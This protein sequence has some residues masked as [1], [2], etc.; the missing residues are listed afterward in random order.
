MNKKSQEKPINAH[1]IETAFNE[2]NILSLLETLSIGI[3]HSINIIKEITHNPVNKS[4]LIEIPD[5]GA[6]ANQILLS[7]KQGQPTVDQVY[8]AIYQLGADCQNRIIAF[9][10]GHHWDDKENPGADIDKV[11]SLADTMNEY[12][13]GIYLVKMSCDSTASDLEYEILA[14]PNDN[15]KFSKTQCPT[16]EQFTESE[17]WQIHF[18]PADFIFQ[19][20]AFQSDFDP[21]RESGLY[22]EVGGLGIETKWAGN[23][24]MILATDT[25]TNDN[26]L[27]RIWN[28]KKDEILDMFKGCDI[29]LLYRSGC[30]Q[31]M[32]IVVFDKPIG[33]LA[34]VPWKEKS[35]YAGL[36]FSKYMQ[37]EVF[38]ER[39]LQD[40]HNSG[41]TNNAST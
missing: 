19:E 38:M 36:L 37:F 2:K 6:G 3:F 9:T 5:G 33:D 18:W 14:Q 16:K 8:N 34:G 32:K 22:F 41:E 10:G 12:D 15:P 29:E 1:N 24:A 23:G 28:S 30:L 25:N 35:C 4:I 7:V 31:K 11:K 27:E 17:I 13:Q 21:A 40:L 26:K 20:L 39:A